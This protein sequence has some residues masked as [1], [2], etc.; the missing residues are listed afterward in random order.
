MRFLLTLNCW[1][2]WLLLSRNGLFWVL[3]I[4][5]VGEAARHSSRFLGCK[6]G[7]V[8]FTFGPFLYTS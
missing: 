5:G 3:K 2:C 7:F 1:P 6:G 8:L 4:V